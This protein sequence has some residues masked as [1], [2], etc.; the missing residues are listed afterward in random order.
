MQLLSVGFDADDLI[1]IGAIK[2]TAAVT[3]AVTPEFVDVGAGQV[4]ALMKSAD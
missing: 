4:H 1:I 2:F 3:I